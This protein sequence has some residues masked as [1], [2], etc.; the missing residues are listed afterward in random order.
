MISLYLTSGLIFLISTPLVQVKSEK[1]EETPTIVTDVIRGEEIFV[2]KDKSLETVLPDEN[3][4]RTR[5]Q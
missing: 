1:L 2:D 5:T 3:L 4:D